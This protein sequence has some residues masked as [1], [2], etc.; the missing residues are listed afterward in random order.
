MGAGPATGRRR[1]GGALRTLL[2]A[3]MLALSVGAVTPDACRA[4]RTG[5]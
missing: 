3:L 4:D 5:G 1:H 2:G